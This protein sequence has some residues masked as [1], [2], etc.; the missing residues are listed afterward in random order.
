MDT[1]RRS[2][3]RNVL[4]WQ[5]GINHERHEAHEKR[6]ERAA[7]GGDNAI[8]SETIRINQGCTQIDTDKAGACNNITPANTTR[9]LDRI[10]PKSVCTRVHPWL[11]PPRLSC[12]S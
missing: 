6:S 12:G 2:R 8:S 10:W 1:A 3:I 7:T 5:D 4:E 11:P 9:E